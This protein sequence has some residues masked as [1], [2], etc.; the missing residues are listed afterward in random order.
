MP[1]QPGAGLRVGAAVRLEGLLSKPQFE[2]RSGV[3]KKL[4]ALELK[5]ASALSPTH[6]HAEV[7][8]LDKGK[9]TLKVRVERLVVLLPPTKGKAAMIQLDKARSVILIDSDDEKETRSQ[10]CSH[11]R[12]AVGESMKRGHSSAV[13]DLCDSDGES[14]HWQPPA[15]Q[16]KK[17]QGSVAG[18]AAGAGGRDGS[19]TFWSAARAVQ[20]EFFL[21]PEEEDDEESM[22][23]KESK[24]VIAAERRSLSEVFA[25]FPPPLPHLSFLAH[26]LLCHLFCV[27]SFC[28]ILFVCHVSSCIS[29]SR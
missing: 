20:D 2:G 26:G 14:D 13:V 18:G 8:M 22:S 1:A 28:S 17:H 4:F 29:K 5:G 25:A 16:G 21:P 10:K 7:E 23:Y 9:E 24:D 27:R 3:V 15:K 12:G 6:S 11:V 19:E